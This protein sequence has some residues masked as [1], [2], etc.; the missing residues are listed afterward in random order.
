MAHP[1]CAFVS[2]GFRY[3]DQEGR[4]FGDPVIPDITTDHYVEMLKCS[5]IAMHATVMFRREILERVHQFDESL[6]VCE[7][8]DLYLRIVRCHPVCCHGSIVAERRPTVC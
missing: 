2:G 5:Y 4:A 6:K 7:D 8:F 3:V 1:E